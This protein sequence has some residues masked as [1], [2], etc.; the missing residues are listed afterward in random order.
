MGEA[1]AGRV[2]NA[3]AWDPAMPLRQR[4]GA[5]GRRRSVAAIAASRSIVERVPE[6]GRRAG[7]VEALV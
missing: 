2:I 7:G 4:A 1:A 5:P 6:Q 3:C